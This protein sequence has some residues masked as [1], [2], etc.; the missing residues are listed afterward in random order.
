MAHI[1][2]QYGGLWK[3]QDLTLDKI[4]S[5][6]M[7]VDNIDSMES[8]IKEGKQKVYPSV[9]TI[10]DLKA[11]DTSDTALFTTGML[12][13][14]HEVG[15]FCFN[16]NTIGDASTDS[17]DIIVP[18]TGGGEWIS[19]NIN[20]APAG[21]GI[22]E[23]NATRVDNVDIDTLTKG[24][25]Y[26]IGTGCT[27]TP[28][29]TDSTWS[30]LHVIPGRACTQIYIPANDA[31]RA[32]TFSSWIARIY[33]NATA[34]W[35]EWEWFNP[36]MD[37]GVEYRTTER[38]NGKAVYKKNVNG[39]IQY[40]L[41]G[42]TD[43][44]PY[45]DAVGAYSKNETD[46]LLSSKPNPN[47]LDN[48]DFAIWQRYPDGVYTGIPNKVYVADRFKI[49]SSDGSVTSVIKRVEGGGIHNESGPNC[50]IFQKLENASQYNGRV[51]TLSVLK[52]N[53]KFYTETMLVSNWTDTTDILAY[54]PIPSLYWLYEGDT[55]YRMKLELG[56]RQTLAHQDE[57]CNWVLNEVPNYHEEFLKCIQ[58][59]ADASD[60]YAN[61]VIATGYTCNKN[62]LDNWYFANPVNQRGKTKYTGEA[63]YSIDRWWTQ[64]ETLLSIV[65]GG[66]K[67]GGKWD[68]R[69]YFE[70]TLPNATY[71]LSLLYKDRTGSDPLRLIAGNRTDGDIAETKSKDA[72]GI[73][74]ITFSTAALNKVS[75]SFAGS[76][77]NSAIIIAVKLELGTQQTLAHQDENGKW[78]LNEIPNYAQEL[79]KC[80]R[81][82]VNFNLGKAKWFSMPV[83]LATAN[84]FAQSPIILPVSMRTTPTLSYGGNLVIA[85]VTGSTGVS[86]DIPI[87]SIRINDSTFGGT[88]IQLQYYAKGL[89]NGAAYR[90]QGGED[91]DSYICLSADL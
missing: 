20:S 77:D 49:Q 29:N 15:I 87:T 69:Q 60:E 44:K 86:D 39:A 5:Q 58:S 36:P 32:G 21:Y 22:G 25:T 80:Q 23:E 26:F 35:G 11:I 16:R 14:V 76:T 57:N 64:Y 70:N 66:I 31:G 27:N 17:D 56:D 19:T 51:M 43:W 67:I 46:S 83:A 74:S 89:T 30:T 45:T 79:A 85:G 59:T 47:L 62:L 50:R 78:V 3:P 41:D 65:D 7:F 48:P 55:I 24:G 6:K 71:T 33:N 82:F 88:S 40:R 75:I 8:F 73:L 4:S 72:S 28:P 52:A 91:S 1:Q 12:I 10:A 81:Y 54:F 2:T 42:E 63:K 38:I 13:M 18:T 68:A 90:V 9:K 34:A 53:N 37:A 84:S 61:K